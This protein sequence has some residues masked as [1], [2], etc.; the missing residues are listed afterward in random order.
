MG[1]IVL[2]LC[3]ISE[4]VVVGNRVLRMRGV[5]KVFLRLMLL[6]NWLVLVVLVEFVVLKKR[7]FVVRVFFK[8]VNIIFVVIMVLFVLVFVGSFVMVVDLFIFF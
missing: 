5:G 7:S 4:G 3:V 6:G 8:D 2:L 1:L